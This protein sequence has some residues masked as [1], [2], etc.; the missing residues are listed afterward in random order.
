MGETMELLPTQAERKA[1]ALELCSFRG[2]NCHA[3]KPGGIEKWETYLPLAD[4]ALAE[5]ARI[6]AARPAPLPAPVEEGTR[7][8]INALSVTTRALEILLK[9]HGGHIDSLPGAFG[10]GDL[11]LARQAIEEGQGALAAA[12]GAALKPAPTPSSSTG[13][14]PIDVIEQLSYAKMKLVWTNDDGKAVLGI[15]EADE[16]L[17]NAIDFIAAERTLREAAERLASEWQKQAAEAMDQHQAVE[18]RAEAMEK[19]LRPFAAVADEY[20]DREDDS[21]EVWRDCHQPVTKVM[22]RLENFRRA[23]AALAQPTTEGEKSQRSTIGLGGA[24]DMAEAEE[25]DGF[26]EGRP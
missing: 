6:F 20:S 12:L 13:S 18:E 1:M 4:A 2:E 25:R 21:F 3:V 15:R 8:T 10:V 26:E 14:E 5:A 7:A 11:K 17:A 19:A 24:I 9:H 23:R 22:T 16:A